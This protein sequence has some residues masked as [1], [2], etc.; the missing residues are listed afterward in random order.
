MFGE[1]ADLDTPLFSFLFTNNLLDVIPV[2][3]WLRAYMHIY[4]YLHTY[5]SILKDEPI[6]SYLTYPNHRNV[7]CI[8]HSFIQS[9]NPNHSQI[10]SVA[11]YTASQS[12]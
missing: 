1:Y 6:K 4:I 3:C 5:I 7:T 10:Q 9:I 12:H 8:N 2:L 11:P